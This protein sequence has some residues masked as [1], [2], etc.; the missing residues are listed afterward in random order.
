[1][2][3]SAS[4]EASITAMAV[5]SSVGRLTVTRRQW[6]AAIIVGTLAA[7]VLG[8]QPIFAGYL[9]ERFGLGL[10]Q[11]GFL[12]SIEQAGALA[13]A[14]I[15]YALLAWISVRAI[16]AQASLLAIVASLVTIVAPGYSSLLGIRFAFG[17]CQSVMLAT[18][19]FVLGRSSDPDRGFGLVMLLQTLAW[20]LY[21][22]LLPNVHALGGVNLAL[23]SAAC[24][25][26][27]VL[28]TAPMLP[29]CRATATTADVREQPSTEM[30][31][32]AAYG[33]LLGVLL[34]QAA[35]FVQWGFL[36]RVG[37]QA[38]LGAEQIGWAIGLGVL[39]GVPGGALPTWLGARFG[40]RL[41]ITAGTALVLIATSLFAF[42][43]RSLPGFLLDG[44]LLN[45]GWV[46]ALTY[47]M[48]LVSVTD[49]SGRATRLITAAQ[50][51]GQALGPLLV[52]LVVAQDHMLRIF[53]LSAGL[54]VAARACV[55]FLAHE[56][57][58]AA[59]H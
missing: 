24:W 18:V 55:A 44:F 59:V 23:G 28:L 4:D 16:V 53:A 46:F 52:A 51:F 19:V 45:L 37:R 2:A 1:M 42:G 29:A 22:V 8:V 41:P 6:A 36:E 26:V 15:C 27:L 47:Y 56:P 11:I 48:G 54:A 5:G 7:L 31:N 35:I 38:G 14:L 13:G 58:A 12:L 10:H 21:A 50:M 3:M 49:R 34:F 25:F 32:R 9:T 33:A 39:G 20:A 17:M 43:P 57:P 40:H 30:A